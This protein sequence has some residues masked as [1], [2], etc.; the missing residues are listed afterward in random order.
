[1]NASSALPYL[2]TL[3]QPVPQNAIGCGQRSTAHACVVAAIDLY[4]DSASVV[5]AL[6][7]PLK[8]QAFHTITLPFLN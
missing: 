6:P 3:Y 2:M 8:P 7:P 5:P 1:M 4:W